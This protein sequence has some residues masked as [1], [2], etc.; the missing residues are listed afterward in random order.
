MSDLA[1][2]VVEI[3]DPT[4]LISEMRVFRGLGWSV[5]YEGHYDLNLLSLRMAEGHFVLQSVDSVH[6]MF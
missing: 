2:L 6:H 5:T 4:L 1:I 3:N